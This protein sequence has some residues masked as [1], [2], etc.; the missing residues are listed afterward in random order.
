MNNKTEVSLKKS[1][2]NAGEIISFKDLLRCLSE[3][4]VYTLIIMGLFYFIP[5]MRNSFLE[6]NLHPLAVM[7]AFMSLRYGT[8]LGF[9]NALVA[10]A[11]YIYA[12]LDLGNDMILFL[13][14]FQHYKFFLMFLFIA[15]LMGKFQSDYKMAQEALKREK[16]KLESLLQEE[17]LKNKEMQ[18]VN[19]S[20]KKQIIQSKGGIISF[21]KI[22]KSLSEM[23]A[24]EEI[25]EKMLS[26]LTQMT[27]CENASIFIKENNNLRQ[28]EKIGTSAINNN[29][30]ISSPEGERFL[31]VM[32]RKSP[33][34][35]PFDLEGK[36]PIFIAPLFSK[37][38]IKG[39]VE[40]TSLSYEASKSY[41]FEIFKI[42][43]EE[44]A[45]LLEN[46]E[47]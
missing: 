46:I 43:A 26:F 4:I 30:E 39:F 40:V 45:D 41:N 47:S 10:T 31:E 12:Y 1:S 2:L 5:Y 23:K 42:I 13:L 32:K 35:F 33:L 28:I 44:V 27:D 37:G 17:K 18:D 36:S 3:S 34:E 24:S 9:V 16:D 15:M 7:V 21:Q 6:L 8:Y 22:R 19:V 25:Y 14:K 20:L 29:I 11:A 38:E